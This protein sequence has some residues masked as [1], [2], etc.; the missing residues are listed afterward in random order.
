VVDSTAYGKFSVID[1][2]GSV[3]TRADYTLPIYG[4]SCFA[5]TSASRW[6]VGNYDGVV[7]DGS[8]LPST[9]RFLDY[10]RVWSMAGGGTRVALSTASGRV[11]S[12][13]TSSNTVEQTIAQQGAQLAM[14]ADGGTLAVAV[15]FYLGGSELSSDRSIY[16][17]SM[18]NATVT[19]QFPFSYTYGV[20][21]PV[22]NAMSLSADGSTVGAI[23]TPTLGN[24][25]TAQALLVQTGAPVLT[26]TAG[27]W[28]APLRL[29]PDGTLAA[30]TTSPPQM[31]GVTPASNVFQNGTLTTSLSGWSVGWL[32][33]SR[34]LV[35]DTTANSSNGYSYV[36]AHIY[37][38]TGTLLGS[39]PLPEVD[40]FQVISADLIYAPGPNQIL[41]VTSG[42]AAWQ[43]ADATAGPGAI[44]SVEVVFV[45][46]TL[47][48]AQPYTTAQ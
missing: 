4:I 5:A 1:L 41:S 7:L 48:L 37:G 21:A 6:L 30:F 36:A 28:G 22:L 42:A 38:P 47:V 11:I 25:T 9:P 17:Y 23:S 10:G 16:V 35:N 15:N 44:T 32:D 14:S 18:P 45:S 3:P 34:L 19:R 27:N 46:G 33:N 40:S 2:S 20:T 13:D 8:G 31:F 29:S 12:Y 24:T 39:P 43:S 26:T